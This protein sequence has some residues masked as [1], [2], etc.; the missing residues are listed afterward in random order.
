M[1]RLALMAV[2]LC[3]ASPLAAQTTI[4]RDHN[5]GIIAND[6]NG[7]VSVTPNHQ[8]G[9]TIN[10]RDGTT[11]LDP[12][13]VGG[14]TPHGPSPARRSLRESGPLDPREQLGGARP[15]MNEPLR[16]GGGGLR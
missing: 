3:A 6:P 2:L 10:G 9:G 15:P 12:N 11:M 16:G 7:A 13:H 4:L 5:G 1:F 14:L 8:G